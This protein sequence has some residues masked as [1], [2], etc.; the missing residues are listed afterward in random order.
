MATVAEVLLWGRRIGAV[1]LEDGTDVRR[2]GEAEES[3]DG[4]PCGAAKARPAS[5]AGVGGLRETGVRG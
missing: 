3:I 5:I 4:E 2:G 1:A